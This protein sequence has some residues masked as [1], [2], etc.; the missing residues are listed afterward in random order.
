MRGARWLLLLAIAA[1][2][3]V[4]GRTYKAQKAILKHQALAKPAE[5]P[6]GVGSVAE[7]WEYRRERDN[8]TLVEITAKDFRQA[9]DSAQIDLTQ[10]QLRL[11]HQQQGTYDLVK[12]A[13][14]TFFSSDERLLSARLA[15]ASR[16]GE[17]RLAERTP[18]VRP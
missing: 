10:V 14:A 3:V 2:V 8:H 13:A 4:V 9:K 12:S 18:A 16:P 6:A 17:S 1:I 15:I 7:Q 5:L 11:H